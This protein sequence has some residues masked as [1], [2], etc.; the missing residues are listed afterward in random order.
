M[1]KRFQKQDFV[2]TNS[3]FR[4]ICESNYLE[5]N[6]PFNSLYQV[7]ELIP[8]DYLWRYDTEFSI[9]PLST[10]SNIEDYEIHSNEVANA[11][12]ND[13]RASII[14]LAWKCEEL[15]V[16]AIHSV[17]KGYLISASILARSI[18]EAAV[19]SVSLFTRLCDAEAEFRKT[20][21]SVKFME[22]LHENTRKV[23][24]GRRLNSQK[25]IIQSS[26]IL[27]HIETFKRV[28]ILEP[29]TDKHFNKVYEFL[30]NVSHPS[31][32]GH[33]LFWRIED[34][35]YENS[36]MPHWI[37]MRNANRNDLEVIEPYVFSIA[38]AI[39]YATSKI[40][41][42]WNLLEDF[43]IQHVVV[44]LEEFQKYKQ[45]RFKPKFT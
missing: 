29:S 31:A 22:S 25:P 1:K 24:W 18:L 2:I 16:E 30:S 19:V 37:E 9:V 23:L 35:D 21:D 39:T 20:G 3:N 12:L 13:L 41:R 26:N 42:I 6:A 28:S 33:Q 11:F 7:F 43:E 36:S 8:H 38:W 44:T 17:N 14:G 4:K 32:D 34:N 45:E 15:T 5:F 27:S 10:E 40:T